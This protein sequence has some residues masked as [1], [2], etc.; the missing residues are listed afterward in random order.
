MPADELLCACDVPHCSLP[1][2]TGTVC[3]VSK[4]KEE[5]T[6]TQH[7]GCF[8]QNILEHCRT[9]VTEQYGTRCC[10]SSMCNAELEIFLPGTGHGSLRGAGQE[11]LPTRLEIWLG[12][13]IVPLL[14][15]HLQGHPCPG[16]T[17]ASET[18]LCVPS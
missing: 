6:I 7:R 8:S 12:L 18:S 1:T 17:R 4:R 15:Q 13:Q 3:F 16:G 11:E 9:T 14:T 5:G 2:C 10:E